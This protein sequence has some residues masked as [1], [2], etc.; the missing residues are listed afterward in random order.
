MKR[1]HFLAATSAGLLAAPSWASLGAPR[2]VT[3]ASRPDL[4]TWLVGLDLSGEQRFAFALPGR[5]HAAAVHPERAEAVVFARR[6]GTFA[7]VIDCASGVERVRLD[8]PKGRHFYGHGAFTA[9][10]RLLLTTENA[11]D[12]PDGRIGL[13]D[14]ARGYT[15][16]GEL[17]S[18]GIGPHEIVALPDGG[19]AVANGGIQT[20]PDSP[21]R[22]LNLPTM[23]PNLTYL[24]PD[25]DIEETIVP[26]DEMRQNSIRHI[27]V[28]ADTLALALQ[29][30]GN[31]MQ[32]VPLLAIHKRG[33]PLRFV[34]HPDTARLKHYAGSIAATGDGHEI[35]VTGPK[36]NYTLFFDARTGTA[37]PGRN[38]PVASGAAPSPHGMAITV[39]G[40][41][42]LGDSHAM[43]TVS[44]AGDWSWD[45]HLVAIA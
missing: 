13:W 10:G 9:D 24:S 28:A 7:M 39:Q 17:P 34:D 45:N 22:K 18:G 6:P 38:M 27:A 43:R 29:W 31:P 4:S 35:A 36:G 40:G 12:I 32:Q 25:G 1:R 30:Q 19:F 8:A 23:R 20:H 26:P 3:A 5:G 21:R 41:L 2:F 11:F 33:Q 15:R 14:A 44:V 37:L 16:I 42:C